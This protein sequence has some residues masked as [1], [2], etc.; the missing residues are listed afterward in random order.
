[1][2]IT[3]AN[4][5][6]K[7]VRVLEARGA[8]LF[9]ACQLKDFRSYVRLGGVPSRNKLLNSGL[10]FTVFDTDAID[11]ENKVWDKVFGNFS[12]FGRQFAKPETRSQPNPYGPIQIVM[13]PNILRSVTDLSIT[14]RSAG[15]R[16]FDRDNECLKDS[17]DFEKIF[18]FADANQTQNV[19]QRRNIAFE[20]ELNIRFGRNNSKSPEFNCAVDSEILSFSDAI[21]I[22]VDAC[23]YRGEE[24]SVE[25]QRLTGK[26]VI[27]R[28]YQCPDKEKIIKELSELSVVNDCTRESLLAGNFASERLR[29]WVG[30]CDG[31]YYDRFISYLTNGTVRA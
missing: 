18:Q 6:E 7:I 25:V 26:R 24:L 14:L 16:D 12:D 11:K 8:N 28:S 29:Q 21:Y 20:R 17:Q 23:V 3:D 5:V 22:L 15:A 19:N 27:K 9:H 2:A 4:E 31:F 1:M 10:D 30:E 13:K